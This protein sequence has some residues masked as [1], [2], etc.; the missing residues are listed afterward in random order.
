MS[1][2]EITTSYSLFKN[3][4]IL[5]RPRLANVS[6]IIKIATIFIKITFKDSKKGKKIKKL[7]EI[8]Y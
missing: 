7:K 4:F 6:N 3:T 2:T 1:W 8:M 5:R